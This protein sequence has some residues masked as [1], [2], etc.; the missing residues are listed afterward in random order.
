MAWI[1][2]LTHFDRNTEIDEAAAQI[3]RALLS[4]RRIIDVKGPLNLP[5]DDCTVSSVFFRLFWRICGSESGT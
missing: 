4:A 2:G 5:D 1:D 3:L